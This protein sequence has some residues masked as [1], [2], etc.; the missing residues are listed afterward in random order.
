MGRRDRKRRHLAVAEHLASLEQS[1]ELV[2]LIA[3]HRL[4]AYRLVPDDDDADRLREQARD[5]LLRAAG[6]ARSL[7]APQEAQRLTLTALE[8]STEQDER[9][10]L[11]AQ[12]AD[13]ALVR[14][15]PVESRGLAEQALTIHRDRGDERAAAHVLAMIGDALF[16]EGRPDEAAALMQQAYDALKDQPP[17]VELAELAAQL[18]RLQGLAGLDDD[19]V[20]PLE[21][22][23]D[24]AERLRLPGVLS[25]ALNS[26]GVFMMGTRPEHARSLLEGALR[27]AL[28]NDL[29]R[30]AMR[31]YFNLSFVCECTD[32]D[33]TALDRQ[34]MT[35]A[36]R[37]GDRQWER[38]FQLH[39]TAYDLL[40]GA[41]DDAL[42]TVEALR[43]GSETSGDSAFV[44]GAWLMA[45]Q[46]LMRRGSL[47]EAREAIAASHIDQTY[48]DPQGLLLWRWT[49]ASMRTA[50]GDLATA[51]ATAGD[52]RGPDALGTHAWDLPDGIRRGG[53]TPGNR[54]CRPD[55]KPASMAGQG[56]VWTPPAIGP[57]IGRLASGLLPERR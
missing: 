36:R 4:D 26:R 46:V 28:E 49:M 43:S 7:A 42:R 39:L 19:A 31:A 52:A 23:I 16:L 38:S 40:G 21:R 48:R 57:G 5:L 11:L 51:A 9:A 17:S 41:W 20:E 54:L 13:L 1:E 34:G 37:I 22:A 55:R 35:L 32:R 14:G 25:D 6:R 47:D 53:G 56:A 50:E 8:L 24:L 18:G 15:E 29:T 10:E 27:I 2:E 12:A 45:A 33:G 44:G 30:N 3:T